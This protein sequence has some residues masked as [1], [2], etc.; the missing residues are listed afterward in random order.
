VPRYLEVSIESLTREQ[1]KFRQQMSH[2]FGAGP[3]APLEDQVR[4]NMEMFERAFAMFMPFARREAQNAE[5]DKTTAASGGA[6]EIDD[7]KRQL[8]EMQKRIE[9]LGDA[10][11]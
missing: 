3:F 11:P 10:K 6:G 7:L 5:N 4:R 1:E 8:E 9:K 2:A